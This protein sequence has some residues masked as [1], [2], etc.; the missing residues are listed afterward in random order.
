MD[1]NPDTREDLVW[2]ANE[3]LEIEA[4]FGS[5]SVTLEEVICYARGWDTWRYVPTRAFPFAKSALESAGFRV[6]VVGQFS[7]TF[8]VSRA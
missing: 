5:D 3:V 2:A 4:T 8:K 7:P 6:E 1:T